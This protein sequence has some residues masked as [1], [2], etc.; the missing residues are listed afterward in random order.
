[1]TPRHNPCPRRQ[2]AAADRGP[3]LRRWAQP[4]PRYDLGDSV[5]PRP[6]GRPCGD[7]LPAIRGHG[8]AAGLLFLPP[9]EGGSVRIRSAVG[10]DRDRLWTAVREE[11]VALLTARGAGQ[12]SVE[13]AHEPPEQSPGGGCR[14]VIASS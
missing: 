10:A 14:V 2:Q 12:V 11:V 4:I 3:F 8:R 13:R 7:P 1:M 9:R 5:L 6:A